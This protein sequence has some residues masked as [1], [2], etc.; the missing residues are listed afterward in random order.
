MIVLLA[1]LE[2]PSI[3]HELRFRDS[4]MDDWNYYWTFPLAW[5]EDICHSQRRGK[6]LLSH[7]MTTGL[8]ETTR[9]MMGLSMS[10]TNGT[11]TY[12]SGR[13][14]SGFMTVKVRSQIDFSA[15][16]DPTSANLTGSQIK[17][18]FFVTSPFTRM[19]KSAD[20][21]THRPS[22]SSIGPG[23]TPR[24]SLVDLNAPLGSA[25]DARR[26]S[27]VS[28]ASDSARRNSVVPV[29]SGLAAN[30]PLRSSSL[31]GHPTKEVDPFY[32]AF[33]SSS[34]NADYSYR[35]AQ[36]FEEG[37][38]EIHNKRGG[39]GMKQLVSLI[40]SYT[41]ASICRDT[42]TQ[43]AMENS[44]TRC[45][46]GLKTLANRQDAALMATMSEQKPTEGGL[47]NVSRRFRK[48]ATNKGVTAD[49]DL[50]SRRAVRG[51]V[52]RVQKAADPR[53]S[54]APM[55]MEGG[56]LLMS[57]MKGNVTK[58]TIKFAS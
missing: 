25:K 8:G 21:P 57:G 44:L 23:V 58:K 39:F 50:T 30:I 19:V 46:T 29:H 10:P 48:G 34:H 3:W 55:G 20:A 45:L 4:R 38:D 31:S 14:I 5:V 26:R 40:S 27:S 24:R 32:S 28:S 41:L 49:M 54:F 1:V 33:G 16:M 6:P 37:F 15:T 2:G 53:G 22:T 52:T 13:P 42:E 11:R 9:P 12:A 43:L 35:E 36:V 51:A 18:K 47:F 7:D 56:G 17:D